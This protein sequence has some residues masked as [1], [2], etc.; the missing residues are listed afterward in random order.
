MGADQSVQ[1]EEEEVG[2]PSVAAM[3]TR[4]TASQASSAGLRTVCFVCRGH[5]N[6]AAW[7]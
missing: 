7:R 4:A 3:S 6:K 1:E 2:A 5:A